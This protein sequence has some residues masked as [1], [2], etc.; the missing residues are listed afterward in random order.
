M[1]TTNRELTRVA[2]G[3]VQRYIVPFLYFPT[4]INVL[5]IHFFD[6]RVRHDFFTIDGLRTKIHI[7]DRVSINSSRG[8]ALYNFPCTW[9]KKQNTL[10][11]YR[12]ILQARVQY[13]LPT[14]LSVTLKASLILLDYVLL[15]YRIS[16]ES[17][18]TYL[19]RGRF[20]LT[21]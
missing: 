21:R 7:V 8:C 16:L 18:L 14:L 1:G 3:F 2:S 13:I 15:F 4:N 9:R 20:I 10:E 17:E 19:W 6:P 12:S 11:M 5:F